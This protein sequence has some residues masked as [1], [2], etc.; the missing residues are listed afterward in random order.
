MNIGNYIFGPQLVGIFIYA[1]GVIMQRFPPKS[2][3]G[4]YGYR[5]LS[6][7]KNQHTWDVAN[8]YA[9]RLMAGVGILSF[10]A[11][12]AITIALNYLIADEQKTEEFMAAI[13][14]CSAIA[15]A[16]LVIVLTER[17]LNKTFKN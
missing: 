16:V 2:I 9:A 13:T 8:R 4:F 10:T 7:M 15:P 14:I 5:T 6:S 1:A 12:I 17:H 11:G 3:N